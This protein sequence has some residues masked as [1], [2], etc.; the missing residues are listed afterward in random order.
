MTVYTEDVG[1]WALGSLFPQNDWNS[2]G[3]YSPTSSLTNAEDNYWSDRYGYMGHA[4]ANWYAY[5]KWDDLDADVNK[6]D[7]DIVMGADVPNSTDNDF[8]PLMIIARGAGGS[9]TETCYSL[10]FDPGV[11]A[12]IKLV[13]GVSTTLASCSDCGSNSGTLPGFKYY[14]FRVNGTSLKARWWNTGEVEPSIWD[15]ETTD[16]DIAAAGNIGFGSWDWTTPPVKMGFFSVGTAGDSAEAPGPNESKYYA[17]L[18]NAVQNYHVR[19]PAGIQNY[20]VRL[21]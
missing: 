8:R 18:P 11:I 17:R 19:L 13:V 6:A 10:T 1:S 20:N 15:L 7:A 3:W 4:A 16:G 9:D 12:I 2:G 21:P 14:R 5:Y